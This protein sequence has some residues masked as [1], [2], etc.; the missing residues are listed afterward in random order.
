VQ[1][2]DDE[3]C[4]ADCGRVI[5]DGEFYLHVVQR[6]VRRGKLTERRRELVYCSEC[7]GMGLARA[8]ED[9]QR[10]SNG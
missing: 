8:D 9:V 3:A 4:C 6:E 2:R 1:A 5:G 10:V 7:M